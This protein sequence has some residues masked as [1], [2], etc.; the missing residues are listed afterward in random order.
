MGGRRGSGM[1]PLERA[2]VSSYRPQSNFSS[3]CTRFRDIAAFVLQHATFS[4]LTSSLPQIS[5]CSPGSRWMDLWSTESEGVRLIVCAI[6]FQDFQ[7]MWSWST[8]VTDRQ[9]DGQTDGRTTCNPYTALCTKVHRAV[10]IGTKSANFRYVSFKQKLHTGNMST[11]IAVDSWYCCKN[12][13]LEILEW[14]WKWQ[15]KSCWK[16]ICKFKIHCG[17]VLPNAE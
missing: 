16:K 3:I 4:H 9:T 10:K 11:G 8:N 12:F 14:L 5:L 7:P 1:V 15:R 2:L 6:S 17:Y 13:G